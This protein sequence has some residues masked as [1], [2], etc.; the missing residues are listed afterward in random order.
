MDLGPQQIGKPLIAI[1]LTIILIG[2]LFL[3][4]GQPDLFKLPGEPSLQEA[5]KHWPEM[6]QQATFIGPKNCPTKFQIYWNGAISCFVG[7]DCFGDIFPPQRKLAQQFEKDQLHLT[8][9]CGKSPR[10]EVIDR[11]QVKQSLLNDFLPIT[12]TDW[13]ADGITFSVRSLASSLTP[14]G[15]QNQTPEQALCLSRVVVAPAK[16]SGQNEAHLWLNF[17]GYKCL[18]AT[19]KEKPEDVFPVYGR[20]LRLEANRLTDSEGRIRAAFNVP[21]GSQLEFFEEYPTA[22]AHPSALRLAG[23][24]GFLKNLLHIT[25]PCRPG[26]QTTLEIALPYFPVQAEYAG[27]LQRDYDS[28][29]EKI[30]RY[31]QDLYAHDAVIET[32]DAFVNNFYKAGLQHIF[33]T[34]D[35]DA[36]T[37]KTYAKSS[38]A[39]YET[40]WPNCA[41]LT[42]VSLDLR[43]HY[44]EAES[45]LEPFIEWQGIRPPPG[46]N[47]TG[48]KGFFC[49]PKE[50]CAIPWVSNHGN[51]L[52]AV[53][54]HYRITRDDSWKERITGPVLSACDWIINQR[55]LTKDNI[56]GKG[57]LPPGTVSD[58]KGSGQYLC[59]DAYNYRGLRTAADFLK[60][61]RHPRADEIN[62]AADAYRQDIREAVRTVV[63]RNAPVTLENGE[64]IPFVPAE[65]NQTQ[66]PPFDMNNFWPYINYIDVGPMHL[67]DSGVFES[68][69]DIMRWILQFEEQ[70]TVAPLRSD[71]S[72]T[73]N[74]CH[75]IRRKGD[76]PAHLLRCGVSVIEPFYSPRASAFFENDDIENY[77]KVFY[78][79]L[80]SG[81]S[82]RTLTPAENRYGVWNLPWADSEYHK[83]LLRML[84]FE[85][86]DT[87][88]LLKAVPRRWLEQGNRILVKNQPTSFGTIS[89]S[90]QSKL[91]DGII[92]MTLE[93]PQQRCP[94]QIIIRFRHPDQKPV[95]GVKINDAKWERFEGDKVILNEPYD[96]TLKLQVY[97]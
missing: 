38:P 24:K 74:W 80:A 93:P 5:I 30:I 92:E 57:L 82:H 70:F 35:R 29:L 59:N 7:R 69:S 44:A 76:T 12:I 4:L 71:I 96:K 20:K 31:W 49:P 91:R 58:D 95:S 10:F 6:T 9:G 67:V 83:M 81:V 25:V 97:F 13:Q 15:L 41:T 21:R 53:C 63:K 94:K 14:D 8:F 27:Y 64:K 85:K 60:A 89:F 32:P 79:Q 77:L 86:G 36:V 46:M 23:Q 34:A 66:P 11:S 22:E 55:S 48:E 2:V 28:E 18:I 90:T 56:F 47:D 40:I 54:E 26:G 19:D 45:Y 62:Q 42:A 51:I 73:E 16:D 88:C 87:L 65:I 61:I 50:Y 43:G 72:L 39:W 84:V 33:I 3:L 68:D 52:W 17:S 1:G 37:G 75:S 78:H